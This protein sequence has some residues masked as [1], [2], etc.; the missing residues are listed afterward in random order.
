VR[1]RRSAVPADRG[2]IHRARLP[3]PRLQKTTGSAFVLNMW[4]EKNR[5]EAD[6]SAPKSFM[7]PAGAASPTRYFTAGT[8]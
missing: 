1:V 8:A 3:L 2:A 5:V 7:L 6:H 4:I